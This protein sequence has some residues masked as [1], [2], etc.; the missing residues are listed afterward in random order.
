MYL[1][2]LQE[3]TFIVVEIQHGLPHGYKIQNKIQ[4]ETLMTASVVKQEWFLT[5]YVLDLALRIVYSIPV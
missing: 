2:I 4:P 1:N 3:A 5:P